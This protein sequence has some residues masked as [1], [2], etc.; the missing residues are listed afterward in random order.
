MRWSFS[1]EDVDLL[2][3]LGMN[4]IRLD[5]SWEAAEPTRGVFNQSYFDQVHKIID[6]CATRGI[7][8]LIE[9]HQDLYSAK[10]C[11]NGAPKWASRPI[12]TRSPF[13]FPFPTRLPFKYNVV[14]HDPDKNQCINGFVNFGFYYFAHS[15]SQAFQDL[16][17]NY[18]GYR[19]RFLAFWKKVAFEFKDKR[20][21][22]GYELF[23]G[24]ISLL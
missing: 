16:Y 18:N 11:G 3:D 2:A 19:D 12:K 9:F 7:Y 5:V 6:M 15:L 10:Y 14:N 4:A 1:K 13:R 17:S 22:I 21:L 8:V 24:K 20:N 23:N